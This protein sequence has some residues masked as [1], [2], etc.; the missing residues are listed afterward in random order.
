MSQRPSPLTLWPSDFTLA[1]PGQQPARVPECGHEVPTLHLEHEADRSE[2]RQLRRYAPPAPPLYLSPNVTS[3]SPMSPPSLLEI[4]YYN[5]VTRYPGSIDVPVFW[6]VQQT[7]DGGSGFADCRGWSV[8]VLSTPMTPWFGERAPAEGWESV[9]A[10][11]T[12]LPERPPTAILCRQAPGAMLRVE[13][14]CRGWLWP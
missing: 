7:G 10:S 5:T 12:V 3:L 1:R 13:S 9:F 11:G 6:G 8:G 14:G 2:N 4:I